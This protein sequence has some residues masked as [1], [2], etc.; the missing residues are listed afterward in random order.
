MKNIEYDI[1]K[2]NKIDPFSLFIDIFKH[3]TN[4]MDSHCSLEDIMEARQFKYIY[5]LKQRKRL[6]LY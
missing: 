1:G 4:L 5:I 3:M 6:V 2:T